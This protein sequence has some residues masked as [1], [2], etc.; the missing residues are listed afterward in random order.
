M[1]T[2]AKSNIEIVADYEA[3]ALRS[4]ELFV[5]DA[6][7]A[8]NERGVFYVAVSGG[9]T[10]RPF[11]KLLGEDAKSKSLSWD[12]IHLFWVDERMV[13]PDSEWSNYKL[14][15]DTFLDKVG[16]PEENV[17]RIPTEH[18]NF[19]MAVHEY[20]DVIR[21]VLGTGKDKVPEFDLIM[22]GM[23]SDGHL[24]SLFPNSYAP[25]DTAD[26]ACVVYC[27]DEKLDRITLTPPILRAGRHLIVLV[28]GEAKADI[29]K[30]VLSSEPD[31]VHYPIHT[32]WPVLDK[33]SWL[34]DRQ[35]AKLL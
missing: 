9:H 30:E 21:N 15:A 34:A 33:V 1:E 11:F 5:S 32:L 6:Q 23:G 18:G 29:L 20:V 10:P 19:D 16:I 14:V 2:V 3:L 13:P 28:S 7:K 27:L 4:F 24:G 31:E 8:I 12:K 26:L 22:L 17:H 35:A 25:F